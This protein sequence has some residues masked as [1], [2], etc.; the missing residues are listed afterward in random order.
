MNLRTVR[1]GLA[2]A[3]LLCVSACGDKVDRDAPLAFVPADT[4][5]VFANLE[6]VPESIRT[7]Y[8]QQ[9][10]AAWP[11]MLGMFD[12]AL[13]DIETAYAAAVDS[14]EGDDADE[15]D[16]DPADAAT[17]IAKPN[18]ASAAARVLKGVLDELRTLDTPAKWR[19][20]G[21]S[22]EARMAFYGIGLLPVLRLELSDPDAFRALV[23]RLEQRAGSKLGTAQVG[24]QSL[25]TFGTDEVGGILAIQGSHLVLG[26]MPGNAGDA[27]KRSVLGLDRPAKSLADS[28]AL[29]D[30]NQARGYLPH[31]SGWIDT[32]RIVALVG[33]DEGVNAI[34]RAAGSEPPT[35]DA[36]CRSE[37]DAIAAK[38]P[39]VAFG[40]TALDGERMSMHSRVD[41]E[42]ALAQ[43]LLALGSST[44]GGAT[45]EALFDFGIALPVLGLRDFFLAQAD[46][47]A[48]APF[49]C[50][51][52][53][54]LN[55]AFAEARPKLEGMLPP[56]LANLSG[57]RLTATRLA[58]PQGS[59]KPDF[60]GT[61]VVGSSS[62]ALL[63][64]LAQMA[65][66]ELQ[67][68]TLLA[69]GKPV[70]IPASA[71]PPGYGDI[72]VSVAM[73][74]K[75]LA[76]AIG[77]DEAA[78]LGTTVA[79]APSKPGVWLDTSMSGSVY[80]LFGDAID[81]F[82]AF[83]PDSD[84]QQFEAQRK[85]Y[86]MYAQWFRRFDLQVAVVPEGIDFSETIEFAAP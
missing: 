8:E 41:L 28:G 55:E 68:I 47:V 22:P 65:S 18:G 60:A 19:G 35:L 40:Y 66:P 27:L 31:G 26:L 58:W 21:L 42:P 86:A 10:Q 64:G 32:R 12:G 75:T 51:H 84:R 76:L 61:L 54:G 4:P 43:S 25:W 17:A 13:A 45:R 7:R 80:G 48:K 85:L 38:A 37:I 59:D 57:L 72:P 9:M 36:A 83:L 11:V 20:V 81:R 5:W 71:L 46:A 49:Q 44:P 1:G 82:G 23:A 6:P 16:G 73:G 52:L 67:K 24:D 62:P 69:D 70:A 78:R 34:A 74:E 33:T 63:A 29:A 15:G 14:A 39:R 3:A 30:F 2:L 50:G 79:A 56:P 77:K 53:K